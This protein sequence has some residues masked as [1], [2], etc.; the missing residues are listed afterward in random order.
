V[1]LSSLSSIVPSLRMCGGLPLRSGAYTFIVCYAVIA[2]PFALLRAKSGHV[3]RNSYNFSVGKPERKA[4]FVRL[5]R[6]W[7]D[8]IKTD[9]AGTGY[10]DG[11]LGSNC[12]G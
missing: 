10:G 1:K 4:T 2:L 8:N 6:R 11:G 5:S 3:A 9:L 7:G 12:S